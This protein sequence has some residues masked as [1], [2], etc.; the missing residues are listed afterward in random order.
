MVTKW[1][2]YYFFLMCT[3]ARK[4]GHY[5][6]VLADDCSLITRSSDYHYFHLPQEIPCGAWT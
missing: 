2:I 1:V 6:S 5:C 3:T 4:N